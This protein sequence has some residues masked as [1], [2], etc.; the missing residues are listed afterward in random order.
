MK[1]LNLKGVSVQ[2]WVRTI[3]LSLALI[4]QALVMF[5]ITKTEIELEQWT[6]WASYI[7]TVVTAIWSWWKNNSFT[8]KAQEAD[9]LVNPQG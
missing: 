1:K 7:F 9:I 6:Q 5:G 2:T 8:D 3:V 4:N